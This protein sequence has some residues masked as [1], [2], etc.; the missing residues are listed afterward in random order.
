LNT[1]SKKPIGIIIALV[2]VI[3]IVGVIGVSVYQFIDSGTIPFLKPK[4]SGTYTAQVSAFGISVAEIS[5]SFRGSNEFSVNASTLGG[6]YNSSALNGTYKIEDY[7][8][9]FTFDDGST[10]RG[11]FSSEVLEITEIRIDILDL[12]RL[13]FKK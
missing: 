3:S 13:T 6:F 1:A 8:I 2:L 9:I 11:T 10:A 4:P 7:D 12:G 5:I